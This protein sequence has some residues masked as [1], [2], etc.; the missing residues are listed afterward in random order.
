MML[1]EE[2][3]ME[4]RKTTKEKKKWKHMGHKCKQKHALQLSRQ[5][6]IIE[7]ET[8]S[9]KTKLGPSKNCNQWKKRKK[10]W[11]SPDRHFGLFPGSI[12][13][14][15]LPQILTQDQAQTDTHSRTSSRGT[16]FDQLRSSLR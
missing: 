14:L 12:L 1:P 8:L 5:D 6:K 3:P 13:V 2:I 10:S 9:V 11:K 15:T 7:I 4:P 16:I